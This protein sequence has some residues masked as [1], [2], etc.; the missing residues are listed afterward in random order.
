MTVPIKGG[1]P[2]KF[3]SKGA[4]A[5][6]INRYFRECDPHVK[7]VD[8]I[9]TENGKQ[10]VVKDKIITKQVP[11]TIT[12]LALALGTSRIV[13]LDYENKDEYSNTIKEAK[14]KCENFAEN[15]LFQGGQ[16]A[17]PIF[18]LKNNYRRWKEKSEVA[19]SGLKDLLN[20]IHDE[21]KSTI[22]KEQD[23]GTFEVNDAVITGTTDK[24]EGQEVENKSPL[25][26]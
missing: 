16:A 25:L 17:G 19:I 6:S 10:I 1:R 9:K 7:E 2:L 18:N 3:K 12:G 22:N 8:V 14:R 23:S 4:L 15:R 11:Y 24:D 20:E 21:D 5:K 13:L 26:D